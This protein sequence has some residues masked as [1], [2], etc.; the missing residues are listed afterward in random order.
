MVKQ[1][2]LSRLPNGGQVLMFRQGKDAAA[3]KRK[4]VDK[5]IIYLFYPIKNIL[6]DNSYILFCIFRQT[7]KL[8][9]QNNL[10][11]ERLE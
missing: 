6:I 9:L 1:L 10:N 4:S 8:W 2:I 7:K 3:S 5:V 11:L